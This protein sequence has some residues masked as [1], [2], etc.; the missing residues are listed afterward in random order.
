MRPKKSSPRS[1]W[2]QIV[3]SPH[4]TAVLAFPH[5]VETLVVNPETLLQEQQMAIFLRDMQAHVVGVYDQTVSFADFAEDL[6]AALD[7]S[8]SS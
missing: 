3:Q 5:G 7:E 8:L 4:K 2:K 6:Q 1:L